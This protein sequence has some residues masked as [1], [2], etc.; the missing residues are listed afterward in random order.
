MKVGE[1]YTYDSYPHHSTNT[2]RIREVYFDTI[3]KR[4]SVKYDTIGSYL[5]KMF[6]YLECTGMELLRN[7]INFKK[8]TKKEWYRAVRLY[9]EKYKDWLYNEIS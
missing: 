3:Y 1:V 6:Y 5:D 7:N 4:A 2:I 8:A 9:N